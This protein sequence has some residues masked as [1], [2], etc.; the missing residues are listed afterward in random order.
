MAMRTFTAVKEVKMLSDYSQF[1]NM[2]ER[3]TQNFSFLDLRAKLVQNKKN[4]MAFCTLLLIASVLLGSTIFFMQAGVATL[5]QFAGFIALGYMHVAIMQGNLAILQ[6]P[7]KLVYSLLLTAGVFIVLS[8]L[9]FLTHAYTLLVVS[10]AGC[11]FLLV[12]VLG[13]LWRLYNRIYESTI[14][15]WYYAGE[16]SLPQDTDFLKTI[17][18]RVRVQ[19]EQ[20]GRV[21]HAISFRAPVKLNL[22]TIFYQLIKEHNESGKT[23]VEF[24]DRSKKPFGWVFFT[25]SFAGWS[26]S[27]DPEASLTENGI[28]PNAIIIARQIPE[29]VL[30]KTPV[31]KSQTA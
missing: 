16:L 20:H 22:G 10:A 12:Y 2:V 25:P 27:L 17:L 8:I 4:V 31:R 19:I 14:S 30:S 24:M 7:E 3:Q 5:V 15:P 28:G 9:Y 18:L 13:E 26:K 6:P 21:E 29:K 11:S 1:L 23:P